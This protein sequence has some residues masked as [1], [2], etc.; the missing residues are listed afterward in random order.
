M[1]L[2]GEIDG[3]VI[4]TLFNKKLIIKNMI[5]FP[6]FLHEDIPFI[7]KS[8]LYAKNILILNKVI[9][10]KRNH[11]KSIVNNINEKR[12]IGILR[13][14]RSLPKILNKEKYYLYT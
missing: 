12:I 10:L 5:T 7:F 4:F 14:W 8:Y 13:A 2:A 6:K 1:F 9:Y 3:S 11:N